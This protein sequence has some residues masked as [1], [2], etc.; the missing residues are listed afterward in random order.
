MPLETLRVI[1]ARLLKAAR[2]SAAL[3]R[4]SGA[5]TVAAI[6][7]ACLGFCYWWLAARLFPPEA[8]GRA[9][10]LLSVMGLLGLLGD[11]GLGTLLVGELC[12]SPGKVRGL[13]GAA[14]VI[15]FGLAVALALVF[16]LAAPLFGH[17]ALVKGKSAELLFVFGCGLTAV[18]M[19]GSQAFLGT[20]NGTAR[21]IQ[22]V[23][24]SALKLAMIGM[25][26]AAGAIDD[27][28]I[29]LTWVAGLVVS[30]IGVDIATRG[31]ARRLLGRPDF[32][33]LHTLRRKVVDHYALDVALQ[34]PGLVVPFLVVVLLTPTTNAA[35]AA[36]WM[37]VTTAAVIPAV[38][39]TVLFPVARAGPQRS[40][41]NFAISLGVSLLFSMVC[42]VLV[43]LYSRQIL[44]LFNPAYPDIA[45][46]SLRFLGFSLL[47]LTL[48]FHAC[49]LARLADAMRR[50]S[51]WFMLG[52][53]M[54]LCFAI[55]GAKLG[56]LEG[57][58]VG[59]TSA[60]SIEGVCLLYAGYAGYTRLASGRTYPDHDPHPMPRSMFDVSEA[61]EAAAASPGRDGSC[62]DLYIVAKGSDR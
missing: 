21:M 11:A 56:G 35:F 5:L 15:A 53:L 19:V 36:V 32:G 51:L 29:L 41:D 43:L 40:R 27:T 3:L 44:A 26:V 18:T 45:G 33:L 14:A 8:I 6:V 20:L 7:S 54:E 39:A 30:W 57:L 50:A 52:G 37:L 2:K 34:A 12:R 59:W 49:T 61:Q 24:F 10:A 62:V 42:A 38:L 16:V 17:A 1:P 23:L 58:V 48:K 47:G 25:A 22:Q 31:S 46:T 55:V 13:V 28:A 9:S 4:N 60:V